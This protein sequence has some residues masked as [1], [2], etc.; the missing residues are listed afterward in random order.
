MFLFNLF[1]A[2]KPKYT[3]QDALEAVDSNP[4]N[5]KLVEEFRKDKEVV[6][7]AVTKNCSAFEFASPNLREDKEFITYLVIEKNIH[8]IIKYTPDKIRLDEKFITKLA[9]QNDKVLMYVSSDI[10]TKVLKNIP[11]NND[12]S[13]TPSTLVRS[14]TDEKLY[15]ITAKKEEV[16]KET[17]KEKIS[18]RIL[19]K[20]DSNIKLNFGK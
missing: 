11:D 12:Y 16:T 7:K 1:N 8:Q 17:L 4:M 13:K 10:R 3:K 9:L 18:S 15:Q 5:L 6:E 2:K 19:E 20:E 14:D